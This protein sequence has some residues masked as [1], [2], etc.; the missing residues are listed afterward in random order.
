MKQSIKRFYETFGEKGILFILF[1]FSV[2]IHSLLAA[3]M[4]LPAIYPDEIGTAAVAAFY[5]GRDWSGMM[6]QIGY[7]YGYIQALF[8]A[9]LMLIFKS[10]YALYKA[11]LVTNGVMISCIPMIAYHLSTK[12]GIKEGSEW[13]KIVIALCSGFYVTYVAHSKFIWNEAICSLLPWLVIWCVFMAWDKRTKDG[14]RLIMSVVTG[15][16]CAVCYAAHPRLVVVVIALTFTLL[17]A[18]LFFNERILNLPAFFVSLVSSLVLEHF[19]CELLKENVWGAV[20]NN[21]PVGELDRLS[22]FAESGGIGDFFSTLIGHM[23]TF[24]SGTMGLGALAIVIFAAL[25]ISRVSEWRKMRSRSPES[26]TKTYEKPGYSTPLIVFSIYAFLTVAGSMM[27]SVLFKFNSSRIDV[28]QDISMFGRYTDNVAPLAIFLVLVFLFLYGSGEKGL[29]LNHVLWAAG[30]Y[31]A[32]CFLFGKLV[33]PRLAEA[34][35]YR[36]S[37]VLALMPWRIG[38]DYTAPFTGMSFL[39]IS[40]CVFAVFAVLVICTSCTPRLKT[41]FISMLVCGIFFYTTVFAAGSYLPMRAEENRVNT[42]GAK[43]ISALLYNDRQSPQI[44]AYKLP[45]KTSMLVQFL[46]P[47]TE[48]LIVRSKSKIPE[49]CILIVERVNGIPLKHGT[50]EIVGYTDEYAVYA[51]GESARDYIKYKR[52]AEGD[53]SP[54]EITE[55]NK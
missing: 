5:S 19:C 13:Q 30:L 38:E 53:A 51:C 20:T 11:M 40:S 42:S 21:T 25:C 35:A 26:D 34:E 22:G 27:V 50:Y 43:Q 29:R 10:P 1:A 2:V 6:G 46:N 39:I 47:D 24:M 18:G 31:A 48:V 8:Y 16:L 12:L 55:G 54:A 23:Y 52:A 41:Q 33:V 37:P 49:S 44:A 15:I 3:Q 14:M 28:I 7:Y 36:E 45:S 4:E 9:P 17:I 32:V